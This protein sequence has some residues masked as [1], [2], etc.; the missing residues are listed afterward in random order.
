MENLPSDT[1]ILQAY[2]NQVIAEETDRIRK[3]L[4]KMPWLTKDNILLFSLVA[5]LG[6]SIIQKFTIIGT[7]LIIFY[8]IMD[9]YISL[10]IKIEER[11]SIER[12]EDDRNEAVHDV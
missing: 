8:M 7:A 9:S 10:R 5:S 1:P 6:L 3:S 11:R 12:E 2:R 4:V